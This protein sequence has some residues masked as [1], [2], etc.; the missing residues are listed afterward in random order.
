MPGGM[1]VRGNEQGARGEDR[2]S[3]SELRETPADIM[4]EEAEDSA[5]FR[6]SFHVGGSAG[7]DW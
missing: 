3:M 4:R 1:D 5:R 6:R 2:Q 7:K